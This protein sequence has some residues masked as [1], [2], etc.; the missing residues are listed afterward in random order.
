[1]C[2]AVVISLFVGRLVQLQGMDSA[3]YRTLANRQRLATIPIQVTRGSITAS[4]GTVLAMTV[5]TDLVFADPA[6]MKPAS[7]RAEAAS[8]LA[9]PLQMTEPAI[10]ALLNHPSSPQ[11]QVLKDSVPLA[12]ATRIT[13][14]K[15]PGIS[16][17]ATYSR[18]YPDG[19][20]AASL[21]GFTDVGS[22][23]QLAGVAGLEQE[24]N[25]PLAGKNGSEQVE[26][27]PDGQ[28]IPLTQGKSTPAVQSRNLRLTIQPDIQFEAEQQC[29][30][31]V[32]LAKARSCTIVIMQPSTGN[33]LALAQWPTFNPAAP[34]SY[35][36]TSD[37]GVSSVFAPGSTAKVITVAAALEHGGQ[38]PMSAY[39]IPDQIVVDGY[40]FHDSEPHPTTRYT[41]AGILAHSSNVGMVQVVQHVSPQEQYKYFRAFGLGSPS[42]LGLPGE[43]PGI[44]PPPSQWIGGAADERYE[45]SFGQG[46]AVN[47]VQMASVYA[48][49]ANGGVRVQ[50]SVVAGT[51]SSSGAFTAAPASPRRRVL[52][53]K[54]ARELMAILQQVPVVDAQAGEPWGLVAGYSIAAKTGTAQE[55]DP[56]HPSCLCQYGSSYIGIAPARHPQ[57]VVAVNVQDPTAQGYFGDEIAGPVFYNVMRFVLQTLKIP[58][59]GG[60]RPYVRLTAP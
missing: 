54:T 4:N 18:I 30:L 19:D 7:V 47:A 14:L 40:P 17:K 39:T 59:D 16:M 38:T 51:T 57:V 15:L 43:S 20:L 22:T 60:G 26:T 11:Y 41:I 50:P 55:P 12:S 31:R 13:S 28:P 32:I 21:L 8:E 34:A 49:I 36:A 6:Q 37:L 2:F 25:K 53:P 44:L 58:P 27:G 23:G 45:L 3:T 29:R 52:K 35:A 9:G 10:L 48:T 1:V 56:A 42:G 24:Y 33:I 5:Q 46:I